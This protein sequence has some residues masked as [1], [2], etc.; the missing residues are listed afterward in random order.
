[1]TSRW[2]ARRAR[3]IFRS[4]LKDSEVRV[5]ATPYEEFTREWWAR[6]QMADVAVL[7]TAKLLF[8]LAGGRFLSGRG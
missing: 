2:H 3:L 4:E 8:Y 7:E 1:V 5:V 6:R